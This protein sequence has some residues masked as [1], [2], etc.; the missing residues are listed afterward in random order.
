[1]HLSH[2]FLTIAMAGRACRESSAR[3]TWTYNYNGFGTFGPEHDPRFSYNFD[4]QG[5]IYLKVES[6]FFAKYQYFDFHGR[7]YIKVEGCIF[8]K[9]HQILGPAP[10]RPRSS[11]GV[12]K[13]VQRAP[14]GSKEPPKTSSGPDCRW[15]MDSLWSPRGISEGD[16]WC[17]WGSSSV[18]WVSFGRLRGPLRENYIFK[19]P[20][21]RKAAGTSNV[22]PP[23]INHSAESK[24]LTVA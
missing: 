13:R 12:P 9:V 20:I 11:P 7:I 24:S 15:L 8:K 22:S 18:L 19:L 16:L 14:Q 6:A 10:E 5:R 21:N 1:M 3:L 23:L 4:F 2:R 17:L